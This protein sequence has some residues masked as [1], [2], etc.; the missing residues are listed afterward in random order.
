[1]VWRRQVNPHQVRRLDGKLRVG[2]D[3]P[4]VSPL[5]AD[6][7]TSQ[8]PPDL[9]R[10]H[11]TQGSGDPAAAPSGI[12]GR[13]R[14]IKQGQE[15]PLRLFTLTPA[16]AGPRS[17]L[18]TDQ[19]LGRTTPTPLAH[20]GGAYPKPLPEGG[21]GGSRRRARIS[22]ARK[23]RRCSVVQARTQFSKVRRSSE[24]NSMGIAWRIPRAYIMTAYCVTKY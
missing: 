7:V 4:T 12:T 19:P 20:R 9:A 6:A 11:V 13:G 23:T 10:R 17:I 2:R 18:Q 5:Q 24:L 1:M 22:L 21:G 8:H 15:A 3:A 14:L 16:G